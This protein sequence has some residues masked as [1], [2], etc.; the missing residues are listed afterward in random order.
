MDKDLQK[1]AYSISSLPIGLH[2]FIINRLLLLM[3]IVVFRLDDSL[4]PEFQ[5]FIDNHKA[6]TKSAA[7]GLSTKDYETFSAIYKL[8]LLNSILHLTKV[9]PILQVIE[10]KSELIA[11]DYV[12][13]ILRGHF[14]GLNVRCSSSLRTD[15]KF[16]TSFDLTGV[17]LLICNR[18]KFWSL[19]VKSL[20]LLM[21]HD[22]L[23]KV[24]FKN[25]PVDSSS[26][27][28]ET[29]DYLKFNLAAKLKGDICARPAETKK[30]KLKQT[31]PII[32]ENGEQTDNIAGNSFNIA[33]L[34]DYIFSNLDFMLPRERIN[35]YLFIQLFV[36]L[37]ALSNAIY[38]T[39]PNNFLANNVL[40][41]KKIFDPLE[42]TFDSKIHKT[43]T[44]EL[45]AANRLFSR[46][47]VDMG[48]VN[49]NTSF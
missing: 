22:A 23:F 10:K 2:S 49:E 38:E 9:E 1:T 44:D 3:Q 28:T 36:Q 30:I 11:S 46:K 18:K 26:S 27:S 20:S 43:L 12:L 39:F 40:S 25:T 17:P 19:F 35:L 14:Q 42:I 41:L 29:F 47:N 15:F 6:F 13:H 4:P 8:N 16:I 31:S 34:A 5:N 45:N 48:T 32:D 24:E 21:S 37:D 33:C 7:N